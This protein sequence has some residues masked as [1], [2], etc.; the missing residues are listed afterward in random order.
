MKK[1]I[2]VRKSWGLMNP[3]TRRMNSGKLYNRKK[4]FKKTFDVE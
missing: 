4:K 2:K 1:V 3:C